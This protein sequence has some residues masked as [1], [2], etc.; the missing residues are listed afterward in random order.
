MLLE[1]RHVTQYHYAAPVRESVMEVWMQP[2]KSATQRLLSFELEIDPAAQLFSYADSFGN[3]VYHFDV[4]QPHERLEIIARSAVDTQAPPPLP[5]ALDRGEWDRLRSDF[6]RGECF[7]Y[8][9]PHGYATTTPALQ[10]FIEKHGIDGLRH[11]DPLTAARELSGL[12]YSAFEY[13]TGV[14]EADSPIDHALEE[15]RG[16]CQDFAH[17][18]IAICRGW[19]LPARYV[20]GYLF[21]D[22]SESHDRSDPDA[23]HAWVEVFLPSLRWVGLDPTNDLV[24]G[25][26][27]V[28]VAVGRDYADV[29]PSR[30]VFKGEAD[31]QLAV[32]VSVRRAR[33]AIAEPEFI[34]MARP[35]FAGAQPRRRPSL[36]S[37]V[38][39]QRHHQQQQQQQ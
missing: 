6:V 22:R 37:L 17:I 23:S 5:E 14:T 38:D 33:A 9:R 18:M 21:T 2:Q 16:V 25:E 36:T 39:Q 34:R 24:A 26:R 35:A 31:S 7:D 20:S 15:G 10:A 28:Q 4:P 11:L 3:A 12:I 30:G 8:L 1:I 27:H 32:G 29:P 19:G 13:E